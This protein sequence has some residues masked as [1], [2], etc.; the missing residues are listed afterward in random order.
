MKKAGDGFNV[1]VLVAVGSVW[2]LC[3]AGLG[4]Y[5]RGMCA[6]T[7]TG[8][9]M[10]GF[11]IF[12]LSVGLAYGKKLWTPTILLLVALMFKLLDASLL[13]LPILHGAVSNPMFA[14]ITEAAA[15]M[16]LFQVLSSGLKKSLHGRAVLG[17]LSALLAVNLFPLVGY[18]TGIPACVVAGTGYPLSLYYAPIAVF[19]SAVTCPLGMQ[20]GEKLAV[21]LEKQKTRERKPIL[22]R[23][24]FP[25]VAVL[26]LLI[27][28]LIRIV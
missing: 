5:L 10:T 2:G 3:E 23:A 25:A 16:F 1:G 8:S 24:A 14:F 28:V 13:H 22:A 17:G 6:R 15:F 9:V 18:V 21:L 20:A 12:F 26:S 27:M 11:A 19:L 7:I 4:M